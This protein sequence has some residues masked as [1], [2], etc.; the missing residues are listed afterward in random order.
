MK[1]AINVET[2]AVQSAGALQSVKGGSTLAIQ[3]RFV[4]GTVA[5]A[6]DEA[7]IEAALKRAPGGDM[8]LLAS[9]A[10]GGF[11]EATAEFTYVA[12]MSLDTP[13]IRAALGY[14][15]GDSADDAGP[16]DCVLEIAWGAAPKRR[17]ASVAVQL[18]QPVGYDEG[19]PVDPEAPSGHTHE[20]A[21]VTGLEA[22]LD[23]KADLVDGKVPAEQLPSSAVTA[24]VTVADETALLALT[25]GDVQNGDYVSVADGSEALSGAVLEVVD[26]TKL[27]HASLHLNAFAIASR[28]G[29]AH[30][31]E[32]NGLYE[33]SVANAGNADA[34]GTYIRGGTHLLRPL[35][36]KDGV[37]GSTVI[38]WQRN[39][40]EIIHGIDPYYYSDEK[41]ASPE[42]VQTW[43]ALD[44]DNNP[45]PAVT[46]NIPGLAPAAHASTHAA[47][48]SDPLSLAIEDVTGLVDALV[49]VG[50]VH[51]GGDY[52]PENAGRVATGLVAEYLLG[53]DGAGAVSLEDSVGTNDLTATGSVVLG[54]GY[55]ASFGAA[56]DLGNTAYL[57]SSLDVG[58]Y[59]AMSMGAWVFARSR[60]AGGEF[61]KA[62]IA[63][64]AND[65]TEGIQLI[66]EQGDS[67]SLYCYVGDL[68]TNVGDGS[69]AMPLNEWVHVVV[70]FD[71][72]TVKVYRN[73]V[74][75]ETA[76]AAIT[77]LPTY[78]TPAFL[79][80]NTMP[81]ALAS[82]WDG[83]IAKVRVWNTVLTAGQ[84]TTE[85]G[86]A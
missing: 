36:Y 14:G 12:E 18:V 61:G 41:V 38:L 77:E 17:S 13:A 4:R 22:A 83:G 10:P 81:Y 84:V 60:K 33:I 79:I 19:E 57:Q 78:T 64:D 80:G 52:S 72:G 23:A 7:T 21:D 55:Y 11:S 51:A 27:G 82:Q 68:A 58:G 30:P 71:A 20:I 75:I 15:T 26:G 56:F 63:V 53:D 67:G 28:R 40:W 76:T 45:A 35:F 39:R 44:S 54:E 86:N 65:N 5:E 34:N 46:G 47:G 59:T 73:A 32:I 24:R 3:A 42:L 48:G 2:D 16:L 49:S 74:L 70:T 6:V 62:C 9:V 1:L 25:A 31:S 69:G 29:V 66:Q 43:V 85:F 8:P 37:V 50:W